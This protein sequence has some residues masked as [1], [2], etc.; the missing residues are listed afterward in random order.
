MR[1][2]NIGPIKTIMSNPLSKHNYFGWPTVTRL[3]NGKIAVVASGFRMEHVC[4]FGKAVISYSEDDGETYTCPAPV[5]DT[6][7]D[8]RDGGI[9]AFGESGVIVTSFNN[10]INFQ[11]QRAKGTPTEA[12]R[13]AYLDTLSKDDEEKNLGAT[14]RISHDYG[15]TFGELYKSPITSPHGPIQLKNGK[16]LWVGRTFSE[17]DR[18]LGNDGIFAYHINP[19]NGEME[20]VGAIDNIAPED[21][22]YLFCE[23]YALELDD[24]T[25]LCHIR[26]QSFDNPRSVFT[27]YQSISCDGGK[28]WTTPKRILG[29]LGG[30]PAHI[31]R[32]SSGV[33]ISVYARRAYGDDPIPNG[34]KAMFSYDEGKTWYTEHEIYTS[35]E[36]NDLGYPSTVELNDGSLLTVFYAKT[37][38]DGPATVVQQKWRFE[39]EV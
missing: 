7:L 3:Q 27:T 19:D 38:K 35:K 6:S 25:L 29:K 18:V 17:E 31:I 34:I 32:H 33:L 8:D 37:K 9:L 36:S 28:T 26:A 5:I 15:V 1:I 21:K 10:N 20:Y 23:P 12:Y 30:A 13:L 4:P 24:G 16:L 14:F 11:V 2:I 22:A 39:N